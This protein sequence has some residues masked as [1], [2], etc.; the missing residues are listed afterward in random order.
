MDLSILRVLSI[1]PVEFLS[2]PLILIVTLNPSN[3][4]EN[5]ISSLNIYYLNGYC[6]IQI[7]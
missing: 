6:Q 2:T 3:N 1:F 5:L 7:K 4:M